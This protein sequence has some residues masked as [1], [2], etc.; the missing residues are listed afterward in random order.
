[1]DYRG[2]NK[3]HYRG[4]WLECFL[5]IIVPVALYLMFFAVFGAFFPARKELNEISARV[6]G[7]GLGSVY[8][9]SCFVAGAFSEAWDSVKTR[10]CNFIENL[11]YSPRI[12]F[13]GYIYDL[14]SE[15]VEFWLY[16]IIVVSCAAIAFGGLAKYLEMLGLV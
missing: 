14:E 1:M 7:F 16:F 5:L 4:F 11:G 8:H 2:T 10:L 6:L 3:K 13:R 15:G 9:A 12:A